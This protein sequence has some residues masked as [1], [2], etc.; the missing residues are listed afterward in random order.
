MKNQEALV[1]TETMYGGSIV[2]KFL[3]VQGLE[4]AFLKAQALGL[5][6]N[7]L[8][9]VYSTLMENVSVKKKDRLV[10]LWVAGISDNHDLFGPGITLTSAKRNAA[11]LSFVHSK[12]SIPRSY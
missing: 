5:F 1:W 10:T 4:D 8:E 9:V 7:A 6:S 11:F 2:T 12:Q 3:L